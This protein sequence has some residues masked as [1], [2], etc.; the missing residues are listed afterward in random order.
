VAAG[1]APRLALSE[2]VVLCAVCEQTT[3]GFAIA[4]L[5]GADGS[6]GRIWRVPKP[7][8]YRASGRLEKLGL[9][10]SVGEE[11]SAQGPVR[12]VLKA[13]PAGRRAV[14][15]WLNTPVEHARDVRSE[16]MIK[17]ALLDRAEADPHPLLLA[18]QMRLAPIAAA[19]DKRV[20]DTSGFD[21]TLA[22]WR[23]EAMSAT[24]RF[25][26]QMTPLN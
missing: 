25:L 12:S 11:H 22:V 7:V 1:E 13:T 18:Q 17:L 6:L 26:N 9:V 10:R 8:V 5:L 15:Q 2:W 14:A 4:A 23:H 16:L 19:L 20:R 3:H 21:H 24:M